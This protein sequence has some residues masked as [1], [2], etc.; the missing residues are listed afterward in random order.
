METNKAAQ[1]TWIDINSID[2]PEH[3][4]EHSPESLDALVEDIKQHGQLQEIV[5][6]AKA[7]GRYE[8]VAGKGRTQA[9]QK[10]GWE[11]IRAQVFT[12]L[13][14]LDKAMIEYRKTRTAKM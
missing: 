8:L 4:R 14:E 1:T 13:S 7:D 3:F 6:V 11:K 10:L 5:T 2:I 9:A 12:S